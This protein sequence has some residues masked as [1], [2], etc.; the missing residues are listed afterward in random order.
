[1]TLSL[2]RIVRNPSVLKTN[3]LPNAEKNTIKILGNGPSLKDVIAESKQDL[4]ESDLFAVN[5]FCLSQA[6]GQLKPTHY[7]MA[8]PDFFADEGSDEIKKMKE[9]VRQSFE[10]KTDWKMNI[11]VPNSAVAKAYGD[12]L[13][14]KNPNVS[15]YYFS[16]LSIDGPQWFRHW[17]YE[18][19]VGMPFVGNV[20]VAANILAINMGYAQIELYGAEHSI[21][22]QAYVNDDNQVALE[23]KYFDGSSA[24]FVFWDD[25]DPTKPQ[26]YHQFLTHWTDTFKS[27]HAIASYAKSRHCKIV[28]MT[29][30]SYIDAFERGVK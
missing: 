1:M 16:P 2:L 8:D 21:H 6:Y 18:R 9:E 5:K 30:E 12:K 3:V 10:E 15:M 17:C 26:K 13:V 11:F 14:Q 20:I 29:K 22:T 24:E 27:Y 28:N 25:L 4:K 23:Y 7:I 19:G